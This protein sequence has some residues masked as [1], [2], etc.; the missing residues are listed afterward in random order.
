MYLCT[1][2]L[3]PTHL[4]GVAQSYGFTE[5]RK[6]IIQYTLRALWRKGIP[7]HKY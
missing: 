5:P 4:P 3:R 2:S 1:Y 7:R 6:Q